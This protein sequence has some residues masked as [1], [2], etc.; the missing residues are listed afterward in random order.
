MGSTFNRFFP[1][2][3]QQRSFSLRKG[4]ILPST[5]FFLLFIFL[6][7][8]LA[9]GLLKLQLLQQNEEFGSLD[10]KW[11]IRNAE[12]IYIEAPSETGAVSMPDGTVEWVESENGEIKFTARHR[13]GFSKQVTY[14]ADWKASVYEALSYPEHK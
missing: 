6:F 4:F 1:I 7:M 12:N 13:L 8:V 10:V 2:M 5:I 9:A 3:Q 14:S 11:M